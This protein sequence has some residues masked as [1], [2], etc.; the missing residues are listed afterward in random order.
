M[1]HI[2][3]VCVTVRKKAFKDALNKMRGAM[4]HSTGEK[5]RVFNEI[6]TSLKPVFRFV[7]LFAST[8]WGTVYCS[9]ER[10]GTFST[11]TFARRI[12]GRPLWTPIPPVWHSGASVGFV[13]S[14]FPFSA[15]ELWIFRLLNVQL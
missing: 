13:F 14:I 9:F 6:C 8:C 1:V 2:R 11:V 15:M 5:V 7:C 4:K 10:S 12:L 3:P